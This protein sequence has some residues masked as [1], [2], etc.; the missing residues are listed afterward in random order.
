MVFPGK[1]AGNLQ[2]RHKKPPDQDR[3]WGKGSDGGGRGGGRL[4]FLPRT[5]CSFQGRSEERCKSRSQSPSPPSL[6]TP[7]A[8]SGRGPPGSQAPSFARKTPN[9]LKAI[10][11][12]VT[13]Y[14]SKIELTSARSRGAWGRIQEGSV[15]G[16]LVA[17]PTESR[18]GPAPPSNTLRTPPTSMAP[19]PP[20]AV[21]IG[22]CPQLH[23][24][25]HTSGLQPDPAGP[26]APIKSHTLRLSEVTPGPVKHFY[27]A[28]HSRA[29][30]SLPR[31]QGQRPECSLGRLILDYPEHPRCHQGVAIP[32]TGDASSDF[33]FF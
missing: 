8:G 24:P 3:I 14:Y 17:F 25:A 20:S 16:A 26:E 32:Q 7:N 28:Q 11:L 29:W 13:I 9:S 33:S 31:S 19:E 6:L 21:F 1:H 10:I 4:A 18:M 5:F 2:T 22:F 23:R 30:R 15:H 27:Q 12:M